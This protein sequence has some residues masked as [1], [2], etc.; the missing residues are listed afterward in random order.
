MKHI[1][2]NISKV[3]I[4]SILS[5]ISN[6]FVFAKWFYSYGN[7]ECGKQNTYS[8]VL[9]INENHFAKK[10]RCSFHSNSF[11]TIDDVW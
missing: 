2:D 5:C 8:N 4:S 9:A 10:V 6:N 1:L 11:K 3:E 7:I